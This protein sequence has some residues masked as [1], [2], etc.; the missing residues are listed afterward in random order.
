MKKEK[1]AKKLFFISL[2][3][4]ILVFALLFG[5]LVVDKKMNFSD[6]N[7]S[8]QLLKISNKQLEKN[9]SFSFLGNDYILDFLPIYNFI[10]NVSKTVY[11]SVNQ[12]TLFI[13]EN[14]F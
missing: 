1:S 5:L 14:L 9:L 4:T 11:D 2:F 10:D 6:L 3:I 7:N 12:I 8:R 13:S